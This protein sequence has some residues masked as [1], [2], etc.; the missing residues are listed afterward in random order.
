MTPLRVVQCRMIDVQ[1][2]E[3]GGSSK[4]LVRS[5]K[6]K[7]QTFLKEIQTWPKTAKSQTSIP[8]FTFE[9][10]CCELHQ[11]GTVQFVL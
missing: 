2:A 4:S 3:A 7:V 1:N 9:E 10:P 5:Q 8:V 11:I 6:E